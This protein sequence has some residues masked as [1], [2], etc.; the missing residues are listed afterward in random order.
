MV[1]NHCVKNSVCYDT[2]KTRKMDSFGTRKKRE[3]R[4]RFITTSFNMTFANVHNLKLLVS[5]AT[6]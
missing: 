5:V 3:K 2:S 4:A 1:T 6:K